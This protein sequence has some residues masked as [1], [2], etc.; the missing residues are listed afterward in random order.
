[1]RLIFL[2]WNIIVPFLCVL[3]QPLTS[4]RH[5]DT[6]AGYGKSVVVCR[7]RQALFQAHNYF[8]VQASPYRHTAD[9]CDNTESDVRDVKPERI[10]IVKVKHDIPPSSAAVISHLMGVFAAVGFANSVP[11]SSDGGKSAETKV[12]KHICI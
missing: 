5:G 7:D 6:E 3:I 11:S 8:L 10:W 12:L 4:V 1:M 9:E 2:S